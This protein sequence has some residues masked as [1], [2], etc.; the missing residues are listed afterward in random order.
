[1]PRAE[2]ETAGFARLFAEGRA[3]LPGA[4]TVW[5]DSRRRE[6]L[7]RFVEQGFPDRKVEEWKF[8]NLGTLTGTAYAPALSDMAVPPHL[9]AVEP[10]A[11]GPLVVVVNGRVRPDLSA[12]GDLPAGVSVLSLDEAIKTRAALVEAHF[13]GPG[14]WAEA[15]LSGRVDPRPHVFTA[16]NA[17]FCAGGVVVHVARGARF[18]KPIRIRYVG[19]GADQPVMVT[20][21]TIIA[22]DDNA[23]AAV[24]EEFVGLG[25]IWTN[26]VTE[27]GLGAG[28]RLSHLRIQDDAPTATHFGATRVRIGRDARYQ[29]FVLS[30]GADLGRNEMR[31]ALEGAGAEC[32]LDGL[33]LGRG[34]QVQD[35]WTRVDHLV[36]NGTTRE[37]YKGV[38]D[39]AARGNFQGRIKVWPD[40]MKSDARQV[41][42][43]I[44]LSPTAEAKCKPELEILADDVKCSHG[45]TVGDLD[46]AALFFLQA[47]GLDPA[48]ARRLLVDAFTA[49]VT[50]GIEN[51]ALR[52]VADAARGRWLAGVEQ[53]LPAGVAR[54]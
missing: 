2:L 49:D 11:T 27:V 23:E 54:S 1:M 44:I 25:A 41:N 45:A 47:R 52:A 38:L 30:Q 20:P 46:P 33:Y 5:L 17:A 50:H 34:G 22:L 35:N 6:G 31:V 24:I 10:A 32:T 16:L 53:T 8:V 37:T 7:A 19:V 21:R 42:R 29:S 12:A 13:G 9:L 4:G 51:E 14:D 15:R 18:A 39:Q 26:A 48:A 3:G 28:A 43:V 36:P 40:A